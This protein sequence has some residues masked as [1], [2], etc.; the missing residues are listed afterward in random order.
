MLCLIPS[1]QL[2]N[3]IYLVLF[4]L[5]AEN[6]VFLRLLA[7]KEMQKVTMKRNLF[8]K[9]ERCKEEPFPHLLLRKQCP[10]YV[11]FQGPVVG[12]CIP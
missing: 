6:I 2:R 8:F 9:K 10:W 12:L 3:I 11:H 4:S 5:E 7:L 1:A